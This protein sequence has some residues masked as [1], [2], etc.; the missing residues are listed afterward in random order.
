MAW[1]ERLAN[2]PAGV[3]SSPW[4]VAVAV[5]SAGLVALLAIR[6]APAFRATYGLSGAVPGVPDPASAFND[7]VRA[8]GTAL[9]IL[10]LAACTASAAG[11][12][13]SERAGDT[14]TGLVSTPLEG[15]EI[16]RGK[17]VGAW[18]S[19]RGPVLL[20]MALWTVGLASGAVH[21]LGYV[22]AMALTFIYVR[23]SVALGVIASLIAP[24]SGRAVGLAMAV[25]V[26]VN[27]G[28]LLC[29]VPLLMGGAAMW[30]GCTPFLVFFAPLSHGDVRA[31][32]S[33]SASP[34]SLDGGIVLAAILSGLAYA[35][36][37]PLLNA[38]AE[39]LFD[40]AVGRPRRTEAAG[41][42]LR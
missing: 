36:A 9:Y 8:A 27:G 7:E 13:A 25:L 3:L 24:T 20:L 6:S 4:R 29:C 22:L 41:R 42:G 31:M 2:R 28:S 5:V 17:R 38:L 15:P 18:R 1:K 40:L 30:A 39:A 35:L 12:I 34:P 21:P 26:T 32:F 14:W 11:S 37:V 10:T 23:F 16:L 19:A 33:A